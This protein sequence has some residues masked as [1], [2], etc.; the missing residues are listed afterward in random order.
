MILQYL[1]IG[2]PSSVAP[3]YRI[4][5]ND[6]DEIPKSFCYVRKDSIQYQTLWFCEQEWAPTGIII[7]AYHMSERYIKQT[8]SG[9]SLPDGIFNKMTLELII[10]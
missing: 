8:E 3:K 1:P 7:F 5:G 4:H 6:A 2:A 9:G 10:S